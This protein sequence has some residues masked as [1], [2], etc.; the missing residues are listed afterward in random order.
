M[1]TDFNKAVDSKVGFDHNI[2]LVYS[3]SD[4]SQASSQYGQLKSIYA[5]LSPI[6]FSSKSTDDRFDELVNRFSP[7]DITDFFDNTIALEGYLNSSI[8]SIRNEAKS[9]LLL[10][11]QN[12]DENKQGYDYL[13]KALDSYNK[14][15][16]NRAILF[17][18]RVPDEK[19]ENQDFTYLIYLA[20]A[21]VL[22]LFCI[23]LIRKPKQER[24]V[25][26]RLLRATS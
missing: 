9:S 21:I 6:S 2:S 11:K 1:L 19:I 17:A 15:N 13:K 8:D 14:G 18:S 4:Y 5:L 10:A 12:F 20:L 3:V 7:G 22:A 16:Y 24:K 23:F 25:M 26:R